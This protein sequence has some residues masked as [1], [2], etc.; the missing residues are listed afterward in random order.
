MALITTRLVD[1]ASSIGRLVASGAGSTSIFQLKEVLKQAGWV[2]FASGT[3]T[4]GTFSTTPGNANDQIT[5]E[6]TGA[7]GLNRNNA[8]FVLRDPADVR[9]VMFHRSTTDNLWRA[10]YSAR[11]TFIGTG[12]GA[13][14]ATVPPSAADQGQFR[15]TAGGFANVVPS[16]GSNSFVNTVAWSDAVNGVYGFYHFHIAPD[17]LVPQYFMCCEPLA[18]GS[19]DA[20]DDD[21]V[22]FCATNNS[23][24][25]N[26]FYSGAGGT[27]GF[28]GW[29]KRGLSGSAFVRF[30]ADLVSVNVSN[31]T[32]F[33]QDNGLG[34]DPWDR[35]EPMR[36]PLIGRRS[37]FST[38]IG[39][40][41]WPARLRWKSAQFRVYPTRYFEAGPDAYVIAGAIAL[42]WPVGVVPPLAPV[43]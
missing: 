13:V 21:P 26:D 22:V 28:W 37:S 11:S 16:T 40:K 36:P 23:M 34:A 32:M 12:F 2:H 19:Y 39:P 6:G 42:P 18:T 7:G 30:S 27:N 38:S 31:G 43:Q 8:W 17:G 3:G 4:G 5:N 41:G 1:S 15:G 33:G 9:Q 10:Y 35:S 25:T 29:Y 14:S 24:G 20:L